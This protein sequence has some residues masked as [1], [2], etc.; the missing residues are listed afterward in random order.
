MATQEIILA[1]IAMREAIRLL[2]EAIAVFQRAAGVT[3]EELAKA[4]AEAEAL[5]N[6]L[7]KTP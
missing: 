7:Q 5:H 4:K 1:I 2:A 6:Q 3:D